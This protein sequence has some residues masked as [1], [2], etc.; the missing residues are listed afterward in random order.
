MVS[1]SKLSKKLYRYYTIRGFKPYLHQLDNKTSEAF[2]Q[3]L[4]DL[5]VA[6]QCTPPNTQRQNAGKRAIQTWKESFMSVLA[7]VDPN[8]PMHLWCQLLPAVDIQLNLL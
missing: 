1:K 3:T 8:F 4:E 6:Y 7:T 5:P 2:L